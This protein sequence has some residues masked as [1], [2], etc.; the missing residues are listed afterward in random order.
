MLYWIGRWLVRAG[1]AF[2][3]TR[4]ERFHSGR[5]E[6]AGPVLFTSNHPNSLTDAFAFGT[7]VPCK[8]TF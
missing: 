4:I 8:V 6:L 1:L 5:V 3:F 7:S 2:Y